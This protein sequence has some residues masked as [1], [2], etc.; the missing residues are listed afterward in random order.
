MNKYFIFRFTKIFNFKIV[1]SKIRLLIFTI[2]KKPQYIFLKN[3]KFFLYNGQD[4]E[5]KTPSIYL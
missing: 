5:I 1:F 2:I 4:K 3:K